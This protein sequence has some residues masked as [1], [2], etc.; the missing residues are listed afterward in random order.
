MHDIF[1]V[2][3][4]CFGHRSWQ[5]TPSLPYSVRCALLQDVLAEEFP[6]AVDDDSYREAAPAVMGRKHDIGCLS[7]VNHAQSKHASNRDQSWFNHG[8]SWPM[9]VA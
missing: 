9:L 5:G 7:I 6:V 1:H 4:I 3:S 2:N 8:Q